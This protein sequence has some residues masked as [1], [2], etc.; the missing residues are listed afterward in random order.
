MRYH[1]TKLFK[2]NADGTLNAATLNIDTAIG[3]QIRAVTGKIGGPNVDGSH[4]TVIRMGDHNEVSFTV[5]AGTTLHIAP[6][7]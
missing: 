7:K 6:D 2:Q 4:Y 1:I 3:G 5:D